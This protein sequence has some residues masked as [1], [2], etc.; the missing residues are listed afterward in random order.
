MHVSEIKKQGDEEEEEKVAIRS[1]KVVKIL[2]S[3]KVGG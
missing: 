1:I 2:L 3:A